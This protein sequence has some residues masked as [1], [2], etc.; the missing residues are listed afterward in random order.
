[1]MSSTGV[2][3][4]ELNWDDKSEVGFVYKSWLNSYKNHADVIP[5]SMYRKLY[6]AIVDRILKRDGAC[7]VLAYNPAEPDQLL[8][9]AAIERN[10]PTLHYM[11]VK[12]DFRQK[13]VGSDLLEYI[14][15]D[16]CSFNFTF[17]TAMGRKFFRPRGG[18]YKPRLVRNEL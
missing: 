13:G 9:F 15:R 3:F 4:R 12:D 14:L 16:E 18:K 6:Q 10:S 5:Y 11:Y 2:K 7:V 1:M 8:G 17:S